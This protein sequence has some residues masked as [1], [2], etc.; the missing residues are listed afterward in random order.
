L[1]LYGTATS[2]FFGVLVNMSEA[3]HCKQVKCSEVV[4]RSEVVK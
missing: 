2:K 3:I 1:L 4:K